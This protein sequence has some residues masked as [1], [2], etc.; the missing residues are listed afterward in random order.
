MA[1]DKLSIQDFGRELLMSNDLDP[2][3]VA[4]L[5][6]PWTRDRKYRWLVAYWCFY[7]CGVATYLSEFEDRAFWDGMKVAAENTTEMPI[8]G[9]WK[10]AAERRHFR[11]RAATDGVA[12][13][14]TRYDRPEQMVYYVIGKDTGKMRTFKDIAARVKEHAAFGPW[15]AFKVADMLDR[16]IGVSIDF[17]KAAIFMFKDPVKAVL[18]LWRLK[19]GY[20]EKAKPKNLAAVINEVVDTLTKEFGGFLAPPAEDRPVG[21]QEVETVL[22]KWKSHMNGHYPLGKDTR[23]IRDGLA[24]WAQ[25]IGAAKEFLE[26]MPK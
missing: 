23:E 5:R 9:R 16:V 8:G 21:L 15:M 20:G 17:D 26:N 24:P 14:R 2:V 25:Y 13:L 19:T 22:C 6:V 10:R 7:D 4:L 1:Y 18:M 3:Y 11:G 12:M